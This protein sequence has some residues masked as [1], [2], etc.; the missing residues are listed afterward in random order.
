M[1]IITR[2]HDKGC[3]RD[4]G[5]HKT[6]TP[7][8]VAAALQIGRVATTPRVRRGQLPFW[9][10]DNAGESRWQDESGVPARQDRRPAERAAAAHRKNNRSAESLPAQDG[11]RHSHANPRARRQQ[12]RAGVLPVRWRA[13]PM[14]YSYIIVNISTYDYRSV[15][16]NCRPATC[17]EGSCIFHE[18]GT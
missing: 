6:R 17:T 8:L 13:R 3:G 14:Y 5:F 1:Q 9:G 7:N 11:A 16:A 2:L 15:R 4:C 12:T 18:G 10:S